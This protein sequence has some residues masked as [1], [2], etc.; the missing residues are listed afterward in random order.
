MIN[1]LSLDVNSS[2]K[3]ALSDGYSKDRFSQHQSFI[4]EICILTIST[5]LQDLFT[6]EG[7]IAIFAVSV[8]DTL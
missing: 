1:P 4:I 3:F 8:H 5:I 2:A 7:V 6:Y